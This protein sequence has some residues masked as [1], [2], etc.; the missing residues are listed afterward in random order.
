MRSNPTQQLFF[1]F[2]T[3]YGRL[4]DLESL[5]G[6]LI[7]SLIWVG[8]KILLKYLFLGG[9]GDFCPTMSRRCRPRL[10]PNWLKK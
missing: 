6:L 3:S 4:T 9:R 7:V 2:Q 8:E 10:C 5:L 1:I